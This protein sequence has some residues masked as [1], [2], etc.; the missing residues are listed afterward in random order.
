MTLKFSIVTCTWNSEP[1][2]EE[3][4]AS[5]LAQDYPEIEYIFVDGGSTDG[6][7]ERIAAITRPV[8]VLHG[9][10]GGIGIAMNAGIRVA[11]GDIV[12]HLHSDDY[13]LDAGVL[14]RVAKAFITN[15]CAWLFGRILSDINGNLEKERYRVPRYSYPTLLR[16]NIIPHAATFV[17]R[18]VFK[19][20]GVF[21]ES[22][23]L[24]MDYEYW[25]RIGRTYAPVQLDDYLSAYRRH[26]GSAT[27]ANRLKSLN[28]DFR[29][30]FAYGRLLEYPEF[31]L[32]YPVRRLKLWHSTRSPL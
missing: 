25:L 3:S 27:V 8:E 26:S 13:Y 11:T 7:L 9:I 5:V 17:G 29:A 2:L 4:I 24:A 14:S 12:A 30:R 19:E 16:N 20:H 23:K 10:R 28:E 6:T 15:D 18:H 31:A 21:D 22:F 32:R 1:Y